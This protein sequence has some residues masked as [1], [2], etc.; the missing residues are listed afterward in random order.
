MINKNL[1][2]FW[3]IYINKKKERVEDISFV[4]INE[5]KMNLFY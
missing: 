5:G 2:I 4:E 1:N 3:D